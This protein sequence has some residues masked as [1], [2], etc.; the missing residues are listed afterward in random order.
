MHP[1]I[2]ARTLSVKDSTGRPLFQTAME[3]P[4]FGAIGSI[5]GFPVELCHAA[6]STN[7][8]GSKVAA[9]GDGNGFVVGLRRQITFEASDH[10]KWNTLQRSFRGYT[11]AGTKGRRADAFAILTTAAS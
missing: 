2:L 9:F 3:A 7:S 4:S 1:H 10:H 8:A 5:L 6:P 11:R